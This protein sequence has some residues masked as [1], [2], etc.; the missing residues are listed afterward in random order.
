MPIGAG[1]APAGTSPAGYGV[2]DSAPALVNGILPDQITG[3]TQPGRLI[4]PISKSYVYTSDGRVIGVGLA[5]QQV[6]LAVTTLLGSSV[7]ASLG[8]DRSKLQE[9]GSNLLQTVTGIV[10]DA[11]APIVAQNIASLSSVAISQSPCNP[12]RAVILIKWVD[13]TTNTEKTTEV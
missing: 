8:M 5:Q 11:F 1:F 12:D 7:I 4:D 9:Q 2:P 10:T 13:L 6:Q 3:R